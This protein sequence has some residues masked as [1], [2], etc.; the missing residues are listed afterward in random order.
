MEIYNLIDSICLK[1][2]L[3]FLIVNLIIEQ[4]FH[5]KEVNDDLENFFSHS[6]C[7]LLYFALNYNCSINCFTNDNFYNDILEINSNINLLKFYLF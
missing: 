5:N 6:I 1:V 7:K 2:F 3:F 4:E